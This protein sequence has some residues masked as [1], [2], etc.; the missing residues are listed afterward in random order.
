MKH[1]SYLALVGFAAM[2]PLAVW[3]SALTIV[4]DGNP[5]AAIVIAEHPTVA[6]RF[7]ADELQMHLRLMSGA[8]VPIIT[9]ASPVA[10]TRI[11]VGESKATRKLGLRADSFQPQEYLIQFFPNTLVLMGKD[12]AGAPPTNI[13]VYGTLKHVPGKF[14]GAFEFDGKTALSVAGC[15]F[16][17]DAGCME[18]WVQMLPTDQEAVGTILRLDGFAPWTYHILQRLPRS[19]RVQYVTYDG[20]ESHSLTSGELSE[21]WHHLFATF[22]AA[23]QQ[24]ELY[25]DGARVG[26][27]KYGVTTCAGASLQIGGL[28]REDQVANPFVGRIDAVRVCSSVRSVTDSALTNPPAATPDTITLLQCDEKEGLPRDTGTVLPRVHLPDIWEEQGTCYAVYD[29]LERFCGVRWLNPTDYG[30]IVPQKKTLQVTGKTM[31]RAPAFTTRYGTMCY[32]INDYDVSIQT[33]W[34]IDTPQYQEYEAAAYAQLHAQYPRQAQFMVAKQDR[35]QRFLRRMRVGGERHMCNHSFYGYYERF[36]REGSKQFEQKRPEFFAKGYEGREPPQLCYTSKALV[37]QVAQ[38]ARDYYDGK[39]T[40]AQLSIFWNPQLPNPFPVE[41]MDNSQ[42]CQ[43]EE[44]RKWVNRNEAESVFFSNGRESDYFFNFVNEVAKELRKTHPD[45]GLITLAYHTHAAPPTRVQLDPS[46]AVQYCFACNRLVYDKPS[47]NHELQY[48]KEWG[49]EA[50]R[51]PLSL[52]LYYTFPYEVAVNGRFHCFPGYFAHAIGEQFKLFHKLGYRGIF[53]CGYGQEVE[54]YLTY[55]LMDDPTLDVDQLLD[56]YFGKLY[57]AAAGPMK[58]IY[59]EIEQTYCNPANYPPNIASGKLETH[60]HQTEDL[61][62]GWLGTP[63]RMER[64]GKLLEQAKAAARTERERKCVEL[65]EKG[66][67]SYMVE[68]RRRYALRKQLKAE[69]LPK[70]TAPRISS[71]GGDYNKV[72]WDKAAPLLGWRGAFDGSPTQRQ[73]DA[74]VA[75]DD[76]FMYLRL[77]ERGNLSSLRSSPLIYDA[78]DWEVFICARKGGPAYRQISVNPEGKWEA[79]KYT[80]LHHG[81]PWRGE[82]R[83][84]SVISDKRD[85]WRVWFVLPLS[86]LTEGGVMCG[87]IVYL[88]IFRGNRADPLAWSPTF[89][90]SFHVL[91]RMGELKLE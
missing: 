36:W 14:G 10:G 29:F 51:R 54:A 34:A 3:G 20:K 60:H 18:A 76:R 89:E 11:L 1:V 56:E 53:H 28:P 9:D 42:F 17:D 86:E 61:A 79:L 16:P 44:C 84:V 47:Y 87:S 90:G 78:D 81:E 58:Q 15:P 64:W 74:R 35:I 91:D 83:V 52:W 49:R 26:G 19:R 69:P 33:F 67:W 70:A 6:A 24:A 88:N 50:K 57:G 8:E 22:D 37:Q 55:K 66:T 71:A 77:I 31:R 4:K 63:E 82:A 41:P 65:F 62:W 30:T 40:G 80:S 45:K 48:L 59:L 75:Y 68:G 73:I 72:D 7:A 23:S 2:A 46:V 5:T 38:D 85:E 13:K 32:H 12:A 39:K 25:V 27:M 43:C 21:G